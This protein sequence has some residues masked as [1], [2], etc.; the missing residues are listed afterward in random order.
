MACSYSNQY[1]IKMYLQRQLAKQFSSTVR[2]RGLGIYTMGEVKL[3][4]G[5]RS[6]VTAQVQGTRLY[7]VQLSREEHY[8]HVSC[9]CPFFKTDSACKHI[10]A[11]IIAAEQKSYLLGMM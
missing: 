8:L 11:S 2:Q 9:D 6:Q 4:S 1:S 5:D 3:I 10:W 7:L